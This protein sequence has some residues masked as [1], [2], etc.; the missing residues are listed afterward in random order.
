MEEE[1]HVEIPSNPSLFKSSYFSE[2]NII[3]TRSISKFISV[4]YFSIK[5]TVKE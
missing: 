5:I 1:K 4:N 2:K 3:I